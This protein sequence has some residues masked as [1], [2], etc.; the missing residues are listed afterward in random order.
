MWC[1]YAIEREM[2]NTN[3]AW[4]RALIFD[5]R[6]ILTTCTTPPNFVVIDVIQNGDCVNNI[7]FIE[8]IN[9]YWQWL[10]LK[11]N[12]L[13]NLINIRNSIVHIKC[14]FQNV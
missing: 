4:G 10:K 14:E 13:K 11:N 9:N 5:I 2:F 1:D 3:E 12:D 7:F 8:S 6:C